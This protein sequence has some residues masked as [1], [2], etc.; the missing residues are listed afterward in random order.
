MTTPAPPLTEPRMVTITVSGV[1]YNAAPDGTITP[2]DALTRLVGDYLDTD[3]LIGPQVDELAGVTGSL[4]DYPDSII[5]AFLDAAALLGLTVESTVIDPPAPVTAAIGDGGFDDL[6]NWHDPGSGE[7]AHP[8]VSTA[9]AFAERA[10]REMLDLANGPDGVNVLFND[11]PVVARWHSPDLAEV[12]HPDGRRVRVP[13]TRLTATEG[14]YARLRTQAE[15]RETPMPTAPEVGA[16]N[17]LPGPPTVTGKADWYDTV[18]DGETYAPPVRTGDQPTFVLIARKN[19]D[20]RWAPVGYSTAATAADA[21]EDA[22]AAAPWAAQV[23][24]GPARLRTEPPPPEVRTSKRYD[25]DSANADQYR[26]HAQVEVN[27]VARGVVRQEDRGPDDHTGP[28][29]AVPLT[30]SWSDVKALGPFANG[31]D[32]VDAIAEWAAA[33]PRKVNTGDRTGTSTRTAVP[34]G[35]VEVI[36]ERVAKLNRKAAAKGIP[37]QVTFER[38]PTYLAFWT[39]DITGIKHHYE[40]ADY[41]ISTTPLQFPGG[42]KFAGTVDFE[43]MRKANPNADPNDDNMV[44]LHSA[45]G[46]QLPEAFRGHAVCDQ[47]GR[48]EPRRNKL[49][50]AADADGNLTRLGTTCVR[51]VLGHNPRNLEWFDEAVASIDGD[52]EAG[53]GPPP[54]PAWTVEDFVALAFIADSAF[55]FRSVKKADMEGGLATRDLIT[56]SVD[57]PRTGDDPDLDEFR[58]L[59]ARGDEVWGPAREKARS[60]I[61]WVKSDQFRQRNDYTVNLHRAI[62]SELVTTGRGGTAGVAAS[63]VSAYNRHAAQAA[64]DAVRRQEVP[65]EWIGQVGDKIELVGTVRGIYTTEGDYGPRSAFTIDTPQGTV[66]TWTDA[67]G[68]FADAVRSAGGEGATI[69]FKATVKKHSER[70]AGSGNK[71]TEVLR[72]AHVPTRAEKLRDAEESAVAD[73]ERRHETAVWG[74]RNIANQAKFALPEDQQSEWLTSVRDRAEALPTSRLEAIA[75]IIDALPT[76]ATPWREPDRPV[77]GPGNGVNAAALVNSPTQVPDGTIVAYPTPG[78]DDDADATSALLAAGNRPLRVTRGEGTVDLTDPATGAV[79][80]TDA[81]LR[82]I[83]DARQ[84]YNA[85]PSAERYGRTAIGDQPAIPKAPR[86]SDPMVWIIGHPDSTYP[87]TENGIDATVGSGDDRRTVRINPDGTVTGDFRNGDNPWSAALEADRTARMNRNRAATV[88]ALDAELAV[89]AEP[90]VAELD[91]LTADNL[92][93]MTTP[94]EVTVRRKVYRIERGGDVYTVPDGKRVTD[95]TAD[96]ILRQVLLDQGFDAPTPAAPPAAPAPEVGVGNDLPSLP[97]DRIVGSAELAALARTPA[98][99]E[100]AARLAPEFGVLATGWNDPAAAPAI[101]QAAGRVFQ[102]P[103]ALVPS[104]PSADVALSAIATRAGAPGEFDTDRALEHLHADT[105]GVLE[106]AGIEPAATLTLYRGLTVEQAAQWAEAGRPGRI[107]SAPLAAY[108]DDLDLADRHGPGGVVTVEVPASNVVAYST[109]A[110]AQVVAYPGSDGA[111]PVVRFRPPVAPDTLAVGAVFTLPNGVKVQRTADGYIDQATGIPVSADGVP[112]DAPEVGSSNDLPAGAAIAAGATDKGMNGNYR[113]T[114]GFRED[115]SDAVGMKIAVGGNVG[116]RIGAVKARQMAA[117]PALPFHPFYYDHYAEYAVRGD[118]GAFAT[119]VH[120]DDAPGYLNHTTPLPD[121]EA[122]YAARARTGGEVVLLLAPSPD[123][124]FAKLDPEDFPVDGTPEFDERIQFAVGASVVSSW[125][126]SAQ[127]PGAAVLQMAVA[128][129]FADTEGIAAGAENYMVRSGNKVLDKGPGTGPS[130]PWD[131]E[132]I[133]GFHDTYADEFAAIVDSIYT[134]TQG[135][136]SDWYGI[137]EVTLYRGTVGTGVNTKGGGTVTG[138]PMSSWTTSAKTAIEFATQ[139]GTKRGKRNDVLTVTVPV[140]RVFALPL[141]GFGAMNESEVLLLGGD[142][143]V[144][145]ANPREIGEGYDWRPE[146]KGGIAVGVDELYGDGP[147]AV[148]AAVAEPVVDIDADPINAN[149]LHL[150]DRERRLAAGEKVEP[151]EFLDHLNAERVLR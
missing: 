100:H 107:G 58:A 57:Q 20:D 52:D 32:A 71:Q 109:L 16:I 75:A 149:W 141:T 130:T 98:Y 119:V 11:E 73:A 129:R 22:E 139:G 72:A 132:V 48:N 37:G 111:V 94:V 95:K 131:P 115:G 137:S 140:S 44:L 47:C 147:P 151:N 128:R 87:W 49:I 113:I 6:G 61:A 120:P 25:L 138:Q 102:R 67:G 101:Q 69:R 14:A 68:G 3:D 70:P 103:T 13:W 51:D 54:P 46:W 112:I 36:A 12:T 146:A 39:D 142:L 33:N 8:G 74:V 38:T 77:R 92:D 108:T 28:W 81:D 18:I 134:N 42:W 10:F 84:N 144:H 106:A 43:S 63:V 35:Q 79:I 26:N 27:G 30:D 89:P 17:D 82:S 148:T 40:A 116:R 41:T 110:A 2:A 55:G 88:E 114:K 60:A 21:I 65:N 135:L 9:K 56:K 76:E 136:L 97:A 15:G 118:P 23:K 96:P 104:A 64:A 91:V 83:I 31:Q 105:Q 59:I 121:G 99:I 123:S 66:S 124:G 24:V 4:D 34:V 126:E 53:Y 7:F 80:V 45:P 150:V 86:P 19:P 1:T 127:S 125:A 62:T 29:T 145:A 85:L 93:E 117:D 50:V 90:D 143:D 78:Y 122:L 5:A 133:R